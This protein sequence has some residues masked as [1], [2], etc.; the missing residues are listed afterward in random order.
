MAL[1]KNI[2]LHSNT[3]AAYHR[4][5]GLFV[6]DAERV[7]EIHLQSFK[8]EDTRRETV[9]IDNPPGAVAPKWQPAAAP[10]VKV[11]GADFTAL[12]GEGVPEYPTKPDL[13]AWLKASAQSL[14]A[15]AV[16]A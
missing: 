1:R 12:F 13:Y 5:S 6:F 4:I 11:T 10:V 14:F 7:M 16:D 9:E 15:G 3:V 8:D 2:T